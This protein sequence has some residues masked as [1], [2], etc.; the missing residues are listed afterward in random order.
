MN[1]H[2]L[3][4]TQPYRAIVKAKELRLPMHPSLGDNART[5]PTRAIG[6]ILQVMSDVLLYLRSDIMEIERPL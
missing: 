5:I 6:Y 3:A 2:I 1:S 4:I